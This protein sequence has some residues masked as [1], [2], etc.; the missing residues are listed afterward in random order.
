M[1]ALFGD[2]K[3]NTMKPIHLAALAAVLGVAGMLA[4]MMKS[5]GDDRTGRSS[6]ARAP[7]TETDATREGGAARN[8]PAGPEIARGDFAFT[9]RVVLKPRS[10][11]GIRTGNA[12]GCG[13]TTTAP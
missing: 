5:D 7:G 8:R 12:P 13:R 2:R 6:G 9:L 1:G 10:R 4:L 3:G 11:C